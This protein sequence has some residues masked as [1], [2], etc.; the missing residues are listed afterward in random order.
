MAQ[1]PPRNKAEGEKLKVKK[2]KK[3]D[4]LKEEKPLKEPDKRIKEI[5]VTLIITTPDPDT[6]EDIIK[7]VIKEIKKINDTDVMRVEIYDR[8]FD[9]YM[10][11]TDRVSE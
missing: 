10:D 6:S 7:N 8:G 5:L 11:I 2:V 4:T 9:W 3:T 1:L